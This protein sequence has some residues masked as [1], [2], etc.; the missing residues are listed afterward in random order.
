MK[1]E[2][3]RNDLA[4]IKRAA[5]NIAPLAAK[6]DKLTEKINKLTA[7][8]AD[9]E[10]QISLH[11]GPIQQITGFNV[12]D[13]V[14]RGTDKKFILKYPDTIVPDLI[15]EVNKEEAYEVLEA[16]DE[17]A[18]VDEIETVPAEAPFNPIN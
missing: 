8:R 2:F 17:K 13:L 15:P 11:N 1:K 16:Y 3:N 9:L 5:A 14:E 10:M 12:E 7:E 18:E 6:R 4:A